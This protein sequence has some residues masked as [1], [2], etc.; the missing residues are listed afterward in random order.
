M[1]H[2]YSA[3]VHRTQPAPPYL[4]ADKQMTE[5]TLEF[6]IEKKGKNGVLTIVTQLPN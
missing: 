3:Y 2:Y 4:I 5:R 1:A 6:E